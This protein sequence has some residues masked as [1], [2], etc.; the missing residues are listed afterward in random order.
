MKFVTHTIIFLIKPF[1]LVKSRNAERL[2]D[3]NNFTY[4]YK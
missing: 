4:K 3:M 2:V 1:K